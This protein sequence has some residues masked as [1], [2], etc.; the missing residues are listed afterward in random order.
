MTVGTVGT[1]SLSIGTVTVSSE[2]RDGEFSGSE[3]SDSKYSD[4][5]YSEYIDCEYSDS[6]VH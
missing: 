2:R 4:S 3:R 5:E 6:C 1:L